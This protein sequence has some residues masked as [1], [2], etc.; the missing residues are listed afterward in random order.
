MRTG[1]NR[2]GAGHRYLRGGT[3][4]PLLLA[5]LI[6]LFILAVS[7]GI[8]YVPFIKV[9]RIILND[10]GLLGNSGIS[11]EQMS[12]INLVRLP[13][14][15]VAS[16]A[17][18]SL[19]TC[20]AVMQGMF[21]NP[22]ADP[23]ILG[24][25]SGA[26]FGAVTAI[27][28]GFAAQSVYFLPLFASVG[29]LTAVIA[30]YLLSMRNGRIPT[31]T[32]ILSGIAVSTFIGAITQ[33]VLTKGNNY[34]VRSFVFWTMG[35]LNGMS[36]D[37]VRLITLPVLILI[38][39]LFTFA[40]DLNVLLLGEEEAQS[41]GLDP[42]RARKLLLLF[43]SIATACAI[44]VCGPVGFIG[45]IVPHIMRLIVGPDHRILLPSSAIGG[46]LFLVLCDI[47]SRVPA[48]GEIGVG[49][50]TA[51]IGAPYFIFLLLRAKK[52]GASL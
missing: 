24:V 8:V 42:S 18:A 26:G 29:A 5:V 16:L 17:G 39:I 21:R 12:I 45:L 33:L 2:T 51:L 9:V 46:A 7:V 47:I 30:I 43:T 37:Q 38:A 3:A 4:I 34:E 31:L 10:I 15:I 25:S 32:L 19:A 23:G 49:I 52:E 13:R 41:V 14:V 50:I 11:E 28:L 6:L 40:R 44:S 22:M 27:T 48:S 36:W 35:G 1:I 20:G